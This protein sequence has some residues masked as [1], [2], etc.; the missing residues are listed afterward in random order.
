MF[1][2]KDNIRFLESFQRYLGCTDI[3]RWASDITAHLP[4]ERAISW[5]CLRLN[6]QRSFMTKSSL[7]TFLIQRGSQWQETSHVMN[8]PLKCL[9]WYSEELK[10][11]NYILG[12]CLLLWLRREKHTCCKLLLDIWIKIPNRSDLSNLVLLRNYW[13]LSIDCSKGWFLKPEIHLKASTYSWCFG[14]SSCWHKLRTYHISVKH[15]N[16]SK[17]HFGWVNK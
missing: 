13:S 3:L 9:L 7:Q 10:Q 16:S 17:I 15:L 12:K 11:Y 5:H 1:V 2:R 6:H 4:S 14:S 8:P